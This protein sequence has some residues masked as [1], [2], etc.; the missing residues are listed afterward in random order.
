MTSE[1]PEI[2]FLPSP[3]DAAAI[4][5]AAFERSFTPA[6]ISADGQGSVAVAVNPTDSSLGVLQDI[7]GNG[8]KAVVFGRPGPRVAEWIGL[9]VTPL[10]AGQTG[11]DQIQPWGESAVRLRYPPHPVWRGPPPYGER[12][13]WRFDFTDEW[14]NL[15]HGR[16]RADNGPFALACRAEAG[17]D[18][19]VLAALDRAGGCY[20]A[21]R[22]RPDTSVLWVNR[23]VGPV[24]G[25]DWRLVERFV[26][27]WRAEDLVCLACLEDVPF[28]FD[29]TVTMRLDCDQAIATARPLFELYRDH[30]VALS[31]A[32]TT[33]LTMDGD[34]L[35]LLDAVA[36]NGAV[37][38]HSVTH[39]A[40]WGGS[41]AAAE[42]EAAASRRWLEERTGAPCP[43][44]VSPFH[45]NSREAIA[46]L[47]AAGL[48]GFIGGVI[49]NDPEFLLA[50]SGVVP[51]GSGLVSQSHQ[52]MLH[53]DCYHRAGR[54]LIVYRQALD[55]HRAARG[56]LGY[57]DHPLSATY[58][59]GW[60]DGT[61]QVAVH[62][63]WLTHLA[64]FHLWR[65]DLRQSLDFTKRKARTMLRVEDGRLACRS[66]Q[67]PGLPPMAASWRG[68][69]HVL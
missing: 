59:Y 16:I 5:A 4:V 49:H 26:A 22:D 23:P 64:G 66:P 58:Q 8:G 27:D 2:V 63:E 21:L 56:I 60:T 33:G 14:N 37:V 24:D 17:P 55:A 48:E 11:W 43:Y 53:G 51:F 36:R 65:P 1:R 7:A 9:A 50:R 18:T 3:G 42:V 13:L 41:R 30:G 29:A 54:D 19:Q 6:Q 31:L 39:P 20:A 12:P 62:Q 25:L 67:D 47:A 52:C 45:Q 44:A 61:E 28:G 35:A 68:V 69:L 32:V 15:G 34:D 40:D 10:D 46:G 38:S 57:L